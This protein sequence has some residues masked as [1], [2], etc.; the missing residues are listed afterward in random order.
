M[1]HQGSEHRRQVDINLRRS[2]ERYRYNLVSYRRVHVYLVVSNSLW[3]HGLW[4]TRLFWPW[5][6]PGKNTELSCHFL[7]QGIF[8][9]QG[10]NLSILCLLHC[11]FFTT[12]PPG[13]PIVID[14]WMAL[15][16]MRLAEVT[17]NRTV[18]GK[19]VPLILIMGF[20]HTKVTGIK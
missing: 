4:P 5:N 17:Q 13:K 9:T 7:L 18:G 20:T 16:A 14:T 2:G 6:F 10:L 15:N 12:E 11:R 1:R 3:P 8:L 19:T